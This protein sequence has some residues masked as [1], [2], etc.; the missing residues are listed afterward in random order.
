[1]LLTAQR[2]VDV[3][4][5]REG[6]NSYR[7]SHG[8]LAWRGVPPFRPED[9][10]GVLTDERIEVDP[11]G[12]DVRG[13]L[14]ILVPDDLSTHVDDEFRILD[15]AIRRVRHARGGF[16]FPEGI[17]VRYCWFRFDVVGSLFAC[18]E[19]E[20]LMLFSHLRRLAGR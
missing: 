15:R 17:L 3:R 16:R 10:P 19:D 14:D 7:F 6:I 13:Y 4:G 2:V 11:G 5:L 18:A 9:Q 12:N 20:L 1:V 8:A